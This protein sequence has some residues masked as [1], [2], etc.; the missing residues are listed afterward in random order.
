MTRLP[1]AESSNSEGETVLRREPK[2]TAGITTYYVIEYK[3]SV[4]G[5]NLL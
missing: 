1:Q 2:E 3:E 4:W 5:R